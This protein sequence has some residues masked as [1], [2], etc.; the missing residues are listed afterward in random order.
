M[1]TL[2]TDGKTSRWYKLGADGGFGAL[3]IP[4][5]TGNYLLNAKWDGNSTLHW[6]NAT[7]NL[8]LTPDSAGNVFSV[9]S[10]STISGFDYNSTTQILSFNTN[11]T[12]STTGYAY[13]CIPKTL[14][15]DIHTLG[16]NIDGKPIAFTSESQD[17]V[18]VISCVYTQSEHAFT[19]Q[20]PFDAGAKSSH[21]A[22]D[23]HCHCHS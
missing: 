5:A 18:W 19:I 2:E 12:S 11:G 21:D 14:V 15:S 17:D 8:A 16:V 13:V 20:I 22:L 7:V 23:S 10:N 9:V 3:W 6:M 4:N 1:L